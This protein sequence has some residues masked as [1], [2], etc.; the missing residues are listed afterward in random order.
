[1]GLHIVKRVLEMHRFTY[2]IRNMD[3]KVVFMVKFPLDEHM[4]TIYCQSCYM[5]MSEPKDFGTEAGRSK[6]N[7]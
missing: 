7:D 3:D 4:E 1:M 5:K 2:D 6:S